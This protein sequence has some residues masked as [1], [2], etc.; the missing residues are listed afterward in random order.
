[1]LKP[2]RNKQKSE[3]TYFVNKVF[4]WVLNINITYDCSKLEVKLPTMSML[5]EFSHVKVVIL[6]SNIGGL[7]NVG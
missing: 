3:H 7:F 1:M 5:A 6:I 4:S 2:P